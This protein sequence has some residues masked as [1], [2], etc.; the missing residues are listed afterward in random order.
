MAQE[1]ISNGGNLVV[2][3][4]NTEANYTD[5]ESSTN[6]SDQTSN[7]IVQ[8]STN[9][10]SEYTN[11]YEVLNETQ[12]QNGGTLVQTNADTKPKYTNGY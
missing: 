7:D 9:T 12:I 1:Q 8:S 5:E 3:D 2:A 4:P 6:T 10:T 11:G